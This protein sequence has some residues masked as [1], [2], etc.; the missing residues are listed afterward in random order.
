MPFKRKPSQSA[1]SSL[2]SGESFRR[3]SR[4]PQWPAMT[5][6]EAEAE[7]SRAPGSD[8]PERVEQVRVPARSLVPFLIDF[9]SVSPGAQDTQGHLNHLSNFK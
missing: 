2:V 9:V 5:Q 4:L 8:G 6:L 1:A 7:A 3:P